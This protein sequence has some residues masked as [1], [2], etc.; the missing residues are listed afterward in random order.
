MPERSRALERER[1]KS[2]ALRRFVNSLRA[3]ALVLE[4]GAVEARR[5]RRPE[6]ELE[7]RE[8]SERLRGRA[9]EVLWLPP[10]RRGAAE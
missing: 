6:L 4:F 7:L 5:L 10:A 9:G 8:L 2:E 1:Q 3:A